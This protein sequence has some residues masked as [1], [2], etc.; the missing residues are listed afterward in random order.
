MA[1]PVK[2]RACYRNDS[3]YLIRFEDAVSKDAALPEKHR[4]KMTEAA[5]ELSM[6]C[7]EADKIRN[8]SKGQ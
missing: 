2:I 7:M 1:R 5:H 4:R 8:G 6:L 3:A